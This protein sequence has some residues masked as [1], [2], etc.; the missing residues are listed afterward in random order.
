MD[1]RQ[2]RMDYEDI[3]FGGILDARRSRKEVPITSDHDIE[4]AI[5][6]SDSIKSVFC[7]WTMY[8]IM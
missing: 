1:E 3:C 2:E 5:V 4:F 7:R 8:I 6:F